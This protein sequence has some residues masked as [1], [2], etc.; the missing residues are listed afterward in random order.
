M[1]EAVRA[2]E[3][4][5]GQPRFGPTEREA[6]SLRFRR[7]L[8]VVKPMRRGD[9]FTAENVRSIRPAGGLAP[10]HLDEVLGKHA[11]RDVEEGT[12][13]RWDLVREDR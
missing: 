12:P 7:S 13:L 11:A 3:R 9:E 4:S 5:L 8:F 6:D 1:V 2:A 10:K